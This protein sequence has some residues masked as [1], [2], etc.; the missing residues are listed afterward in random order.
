MIIPNNSHHNAVLPPGDV[1]LHRTP[2]SVRSVQ[3]PCKLSLLRTPSGSRSETT[4]PPSEI[5]LN[6]PSPDDGHNAVT[7]QDTGASPGDN[8][9]HVPPPSDN[10]LH[11]ATSTGNNNTLT[12]A[13]SSD[14]NVNNT[15]HDDATK[16]SDA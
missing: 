12:L 13:T 7:H 1:P 10:R 14:S 15:P 8:T 6:T 11:V 5:S 9:P 4:A 3:P 2:S 16:T